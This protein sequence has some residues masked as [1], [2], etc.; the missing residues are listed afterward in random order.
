MLQGG[1]G[2]Y[3]YASTYPYESVFIGETYDT[4]YSDPISLPLLSTEALE[5]ISVGS[6]YT[7]VAKTVQV[8]SLPLAQDT[9]DVCVGGKSA[10]NCSRCW[11]CLRT[12]V[13]LEI[14]GALRDFDGT[15]DL[16]RYAAARSRYL[17]TVATSDDPLLREIVVFAREK[18][19]RFP[20]SIDYY[21]VR[22]RAVKPLRQLRKATRL[23]RDAATKR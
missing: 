9:L 6:Q 4:A 18:R 12:L 20:R 17:G 5:A 23:L 10:G 21:A 13:T 3:L 16:D 8:A 1:V 15:F 11:K 7:R 2:K 14:A 19:Y 22:E